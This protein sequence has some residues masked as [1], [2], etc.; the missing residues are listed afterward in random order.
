MDTSNAAETS[1]ILELK[2]Y[3]DNYFKNMA[4]TV[5]IIDHVPDEIIESLSN[6]STI[7]I[8]EKSLGLSFSSI[9]ILFNLASSLLKN[10]S[11]NNNNKHIH[12]I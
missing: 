9:A 11:N 5:D 6:G 7:I 10:I 4:G 2:P 1:A 8:E 12:K 3:Y